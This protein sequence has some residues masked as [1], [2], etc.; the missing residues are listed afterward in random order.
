VAGNGVSGT[1]LNCPTAVSVD[2]SDN[3]YFGD[4]SGMIRKL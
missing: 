4:W 1:V 3:V 2:S